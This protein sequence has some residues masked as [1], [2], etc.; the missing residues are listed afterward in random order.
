MFS[1]IEII[2]NR[3]YWVSDKNPPRKRPASFFICIDNVQ[4]I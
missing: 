3:L 2:E 4:N 1:P